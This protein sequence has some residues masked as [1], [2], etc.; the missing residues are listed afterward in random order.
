[1]LAMHRSTIR[2]TA[3]QPS[4]WETLVAESYKSSEPSGLPASSRSP[5]S[6]RSLRSPT[7]PGSR[8]SGSP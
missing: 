7:S 6:P 8:S 5:R 1:M 4:P 3:N 2:W